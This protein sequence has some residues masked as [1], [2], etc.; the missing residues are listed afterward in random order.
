MSSGGAWRRD[1]AMA[2]NDVADPTSGA[3]VYVDD[4][5]RVT[6][7]IEKPAPGTSTTNWNNG[8][9]FVLPAGIWAFID[10]LRVSAR[11]EYELP[12]AIAAYVASGANLRAVPIEGPWFDV[13]TAANLDAARRH[14]GE[15][16]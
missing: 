8:G 12:Q 5:L 9:L 6:R 3:A 7:I 15:R 4:H 10:A 2:V 1:A 11:G 16:R 13:G 14:F